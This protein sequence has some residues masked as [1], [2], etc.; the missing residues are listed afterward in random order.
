MDELFLKSRV[1]TLFSLSTRIT[2]LIYYW[3]Q[4]HNVVRSTQRRSGTAEGP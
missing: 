1:W 4:Q 2:P 3:S